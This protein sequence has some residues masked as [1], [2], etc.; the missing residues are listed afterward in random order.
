MIPTL[1]KKWNKQTAEHNISNKLKFKP[2]R[3]SPIKQAIM[4]T[5]RKLEIYLFLQTKRH[6]NNY[7]RIQRAHRDVDEANT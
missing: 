2:G 7:I 4:V 1:P 6:V 3:S 5:K